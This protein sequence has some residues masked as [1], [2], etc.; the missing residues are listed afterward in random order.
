LVDPL[1]HT[2]CSSEF[3]PG[4]G[5]SFAEIVK[6]EENPSFAENMSDLNRV[7]FASK[8]AQEASKMSSLHPSLLS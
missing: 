3:N 5:L 1:A 4:S 6:H 7:S 2:S 8:N